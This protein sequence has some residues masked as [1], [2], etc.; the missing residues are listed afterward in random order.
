MSYLALYRK[1][2]P[3]N[4]DDVI[5]QEPIRIA[6]KNEV[7]AGRIGHAY[8]FSG[9]RGTGKTSMAKIF[10][11]AINCSGQ[12]TSGN[13]CGQC[14][15]CKKN[16]EG[17]NT[18]IVEI[19]AASNNGVDSIRAMIDESKYVP[20]YGKYKVYIID[21]VHMLSPSAFN[22]L[23]KT[24]EEPSK[25]VVFILATTEIHK[26]PL[27]IRSRCQQFQFKLISETEIMS[28]LKT[29]FMDEVD[30]DKQSWPRKLEDSAAAYIAKAAKGSMRDALSILDQCM[31]YGND[32]SL[33]NVKDI[34]G[35]IEDEMV[36]NICNYIENK[37]ISK[38]LDCIDEQVADGKSLLSICNMLYEHYRDLFVVTHDESYER[39]MRVLGDLDGQ[40]RY[41]SNPRTVFEIAMVK[42]CKPQMET[43]ITSLLLRVQDLEEEMERLKE[44]RIPVNENKQEDLSGLIRFMIPKK[45]AII[46]EVV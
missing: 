31:S 23:L 33:K 20:Q 1:Y 34:L 29:V 25:D 37:Q 3:E 32:V 5:G 42:L 28:T 15:S 46:M 43:D 8:L 12:L 17:T 10:A 35:D 11:R 45:P 40:V 36:E 7:L 38:L 4:F 19:D 30:E 16:A 2:R 6:L 22:A 27:T 9:P 26:V 24:I 21:E 41:A 44:N 39:Y 13:T 18:D 14:N